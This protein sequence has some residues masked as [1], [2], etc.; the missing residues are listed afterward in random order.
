MAPT[1]SKVYSYESWLTP[2]GCRHIR[3]REKKN[4]ESKEPKITMVG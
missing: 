3:E 1:L 2:P 4:R